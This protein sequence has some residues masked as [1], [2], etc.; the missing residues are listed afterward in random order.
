[1]NVQDE[2]IY[3][4]Q[5]VKPYN[6]D[7]PIV[8]KFNKN[9][10]SLQS[11]SNIPWIQFDGKK[12]VVNA[13]MLSDWLKNGEYDGKK[14]FNY[15]IVKSSDGSNKYKIFLYS[16][17][18]YHEMSQDEFKG[19]IRRFIPQLLRTKRIVEEVYADLISND[20][21]V[22]ESF[23][24]AD[25]NIINF[26]D[27]ILEITTKRLLKHDPKYLTTIQIPAKY[28]DIEKA[29][30]F[31]PVFDSYMEFL[32]NY[33]KDIIEILMQIMGLCI[34][35]VYGFRTKKSLF[36]VGKG[37]SGKSQIKKL[38]ET[39]LGNTNFS[40]IDLEDL[41]KS[42]GKSALYGKRLVGCNDMSYQNVTDMSIFKQATGGDNISIEFKYGA[43]VNYMY[44]GFLWFNCNDLPSF[45]GDKGKWVYDRI[46][47]VAC[48]NV[49]S[50]E[51]KDKMLFDKMMLEKNTILKRALEALYRLIDNK[52]E[53]KPTENMKKML[54]QYK[55]E[56]S[57]LL[58]FIDEC[59]VDTSVLDVKMKRAT[60][61]KCYKQ[62]CNINNNGKGIL[63]TTNAIKMLKENFGEEFHKSNGII[64]MT[65]LAIRPEV[66]EDLGVYDGNERPLY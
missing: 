20:M 44:K 58:T 12:T 29:T 3:L 14:V 18:Y 51:K 15:M 35:N 16:K 43:R 64:Y 53:I 34:S 47:P 23:I 7:K 32:C 39:F 48:V 59:C 17:G 57:T 46:L 55:K 5:I 40:T 63:S 56:N 31:C 22:D 21:F 9:L 6:P 27:G 38:V 61:M 41:N 10:D 25:E 19:A 60:F 2:D 65:K 52:Y 1:M 13:M 28:R 30:D 33:D 66:Q 49:V 4:T 62:Y 24:N 11:E 42:F 8:L 26:Q 36:L 45:G 37:D 54:E 50:E